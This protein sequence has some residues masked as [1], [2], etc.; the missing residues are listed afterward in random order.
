M[1]WAN[2]IFGVSMEIKKL[3][4]PWKRLLQLELMMTLYFLCHPVNIP[5]LITTR[6]N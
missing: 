4:A 2:N 3:L 1:T 5:N 6:D